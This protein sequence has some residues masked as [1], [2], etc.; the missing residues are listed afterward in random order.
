MDAEAAAAESGIAFLSRQRA[1]YQLLGQGESALLLMQVWI[2]DGQSFGFGGDMSVPGAYVSH[3]EVH[4]CMLH[5]LLGRCAL[6]AITLLPVCCRLLQQQ[7]PPGQFTRVDI[8]LLGEWDAL[9]PCKLGW[10]HADI[11]AH[12][13]MCFTCMLAACKPP[14]HACPRSL[15]SIATP[16]TC[17][18]TVKHALW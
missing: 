9:M 11:C 5:A 1:P 16:C 7:S 15:P 17:M 6:H 13:H 18:K 2:L 8:G 3:A 14:L 4:R 10:M 12:A